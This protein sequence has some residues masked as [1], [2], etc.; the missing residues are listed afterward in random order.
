MIKCISRISSI[1]YEFWNL[2]LTSSQ[3]EDLNK[4][5]EYANEIIYLKNKIDKKYERINSLKIINK[6]ITNYYSL[7]LKEIIKDE[8]KAENIILNSLEEFDEN[9]EDNKI[10]NL[11]QVIDIDNI[12][13]SSHFRFIIV[14]LYKNSLGNILKIST[15]ISGKF[16]YLS[17]E[18]IGQNLEILM[19]SFLKNEHNKILEM[20]IQERI[21]LEK[22]EKPKKNIVYVK[23]KAKFIIPVPL[24]I[25]IIYDE[26][27]NPFIFAKIDEE[28]E[29][30]SLK[31]IRNYYIILVNKN[32]NIKYLTSNC[33]RALNLDNKSINSNRYIVNYIREIDNEVFKIL[34]Q[35]NGENNKLKIAISLLKEYYMSNKLEKLITWTKNNK[36]F[37]MNC[38]EIKMNDKLMGFVFNFQDFELSSSLIIQGKKEKLDF[39]KLNAS[40]RKKI[41]SNNLDVFQLNN[42]VIPLNTDKIDFDFNKKEYVFL[43]NNNRN[44]IQNISAYYKKIV[45]KK[46][47]NKQN[48]SN[49][50]EDESSEFSLNF[51]QETNN[52]IE[53]KEEE[54]EEEE[55]EEDEDSSS[56]YEKKQT[57]K[58]NNNDDKTN[59]KDTQISSFKSMR[60][61][62]KT[63][64]NKTKVHF[65]HEELENIKNDINNEIIKVYKVDLSKIH[66]YRYNF[67][68][69]KLD[70]IK[71]AY[72]SSKFDER[73]GIENSMSHSI[74]EERVKKK[75][76]PLNDIMKLTFTRLFILP[77]IKKLK[78]KE[79]AST[80]KFLNK[81]ISEKKCNLSIQLLIIVFF[82]FFIH[83]TFFY[84]YI[85]TF[86][87]YTRR[88][89]S[90]IARINRYLSNLRD[91]A[92]DIFYQ[93]FHLAILNNPNFNNFFPTRETLKKESKAKLLMLYL[94]TLDLIQFLNEYKQSLPRKYINILNEYNT[95]IISISGSLTTNSTNKKLINLLYEFTYCVYNYAI[96]DDEDIHLRNLDYNFILYNSKIFYSESFESY[97]NIYLNIYKDKKNYAIKII[98]ILICLFII[99]LVL[100][101]YF[102]YKANK[103]VSNDKEKILK[104][105]FQI[106]VISIKN[107]ISKCEQFIDKDKN[108]L[109]GSNLKNNYENNNDEIESNDD[110]DDLLK[111]DLRIIELLKNNKKNEEENSKNLQKDKKKV[112][113]ET[114]T[115]NLIIILIIIT[116]FLSFIFILV[117]IILYKM[118]NS[119]YNY[120]ILYLIIQTHKTTFSKYFNFIRIYITYNQKEDYDPLIQYI[121]QSLYDKE[122]Y[123]FS[124]NNDFLIE[125]MSRAN[126]KGL[127][128]KSLNLINSLIKDDLCLYFS[129]YALTYDIKCDEFCDGIVR[130][131]LIGILNYG[132]HSLLYIMKKMEQNL[133]LAKQKGYKYNEI[134]Y[135]T[136]YYQTLF[137]ENKNEWEQYNK[138]NPFRNINGQIIKN[139]TVLTEVIYKN[140]TKIFNN[141]IEQEIIDGYVYIQKFLI[142]CIF[143]FS[144]IAYVP[145]IFYI[146]P[147]I[148]RK[149]IDIN[150]KKKLLA[151]IPRDILTDIIH[152]NE[153]KL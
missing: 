109:T 94:E 58:D 89:I 42:N 7:Y 124:I 49:D 147:D 15:D 137:P 93:S 11:K 25:S 33:M 130:H 65:K 26:D 139:V 40:T 38:E 132:I 57:H 16:G 90:N 122:H 85:F 92:N 84:I 34:L 22:Y 144:I 41:S 74:N 23:T 148:A 121:K 55:E 30:L 53:N 146:I 116:I 50:N 126:K 81:Y 14:S 118:Y 59:N 113:I 80:T 52:S 67:E 101:L 129:E 78:R 44:K 32:L 9:N 18:L 98:L 72:N 136:E 39:L 143:L 97:L 47:Q 46:I 19:P 95:D 117:L 10:I 37:L 111:E 45:R 24:E 36:N 20:I 112:I 102:I 71:K 140:I 63:Y 125:I 54:E 29:I 70:R 48:N 76:T 21:Y 145:T 28:S 138:L 83:V 123:L 96:S 86:S 51:E 66:L 152:K 120:T 150:K 151:I 119:F 149:N 77:E 8:E 3:K 4:L 13:S 82:L 69:H 1:Y 110:Y 27:R 79:T 61:L 128:H 135:G 99:I 134:Y 133:N 60:K 87:L 100:L 131:G 62:N 107:S 114:G 153:G 103:Y 142:I 73:I 127:P 75:R 91:N 108:W 115:H 31:N 88:E 68:T 5:D 105:F 104:F 35:S 12:F 56:F 64:S 43:D 106:D 2:L 6:K 141:L 17:D